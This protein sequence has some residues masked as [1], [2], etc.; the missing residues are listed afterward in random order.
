MRSPIQSFT[1]SVRYIQINATCNKQIKLKAGDNYIPFTSLTSYDECPPNPPA[2]QSCGGQIPSVCHP[3]P[4]HS[5][6]DQRLAAAAA[7]HPGPAVSAPGGHPSSCPL[8][9]GC[10]G[11]GCRGADAWRLAAAIDRNEHGWSCRQRQRTRGRT[12]ADALRPELG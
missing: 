8:I 10:R 1:L 6:R 4:Q 2:V 3:E 5:G 12:A 7:D 11:A 9:A